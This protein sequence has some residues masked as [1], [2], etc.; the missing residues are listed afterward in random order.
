ME[1]EGKADRKRDGNIIYQNGRD[2]NGH[3]DYG[4]SE[5]E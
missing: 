2:P 4:M 5:S 3:S 1:G